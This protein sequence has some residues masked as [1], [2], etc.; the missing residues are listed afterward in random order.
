MIDW[1]YSEEER[2]LTDQGVRLREEGLIYPIKITDRRGN[3][4]VYLG[5]L[6]EHRESQ[7]SFFVVFHDGK[8]NAYFIPSELFDQEIIPNCPVYQR[9]G[10][11]GFLIAYPVRDNPHRWSF[12]EK[13]NPHCIHDLGQYYNSLTSEKSLR[14]ELSGLQ[15]PQGLDE[16]RTVETS[17]SQT[18]AETRP[19]QAWL[20]R[21]LMKIYEGRCAMCGLDIP[22]ILNASHIRPVK[23]D[24]ENRANPANAILLCRL[25]DGLF[26]RKLI[27]IAPDYTIR[28]NPTLQSES[29]ISKAWVY[30][31]EGR[32]V[33]MPDEFPPDR[34]FL[35]W[36]AARAGI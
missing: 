10:G 35:A 23:V 9:G 30:G 12:G 27:T 28:C 13:T 15:I 25:H 16:W 8:A 26:D 4:Q 6:S 11:E 22:Q 19:Y 29:A 7:G 2:D 21:R 17:H 20:K 18:E 14:A 24:T 1:F 32:R 33:F 5:R 34:E 36:H 3:L 31:L